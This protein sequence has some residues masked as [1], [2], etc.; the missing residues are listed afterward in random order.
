MKYHLLGVVALFLVLITPALAN[1][2]DYRNSFTRNSYTVPVVVP[3]QQNSSGSTPV[4]QPVTQ[5]GLCINYGHQPRIN[6]HYDQAQIAGDISYLKT[7]GVT[8]IRTADMGTNSTLTENL[9][10][11]F[12]QANF[13]VQIGNDADTLNP[14]SL[15]QYDEG[16]LS[17][18]AWANAHAIDELSLGN[19]QE[20]RLSGMSIA[21]WIAHLKTLAT[22]VRQVY[23][24]KISYAT[25]GDF[26]ADWVK[27]GN[28]GSIDSLGLNLYCSYN[29]NRNY[30]G[31][32]ISAFGLS[33]V[34]VT[35]INCDIANV[36]ACQSDTGLLAETQGDLLKLHS[37]YPTMQM[38]VFAF[39]SGGTAP[40]F[41]DIHLYPLTMKAL[42]L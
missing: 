15:R 42:G 6:G 25:S 11:Q 4:S 34:E 13:Y 32:S 41:W 30:L 14:T 19:E 35:E 12:K 2:Y 5:T 29:C 40:A 22:Q 8:C 26:T 18:A 9:V 10:V 27:A 31:S 37:L 23:T 16:V 36:K 21:F 39:R 7:H 1:R 3:P 24:G 17:E 28:L 38:Y 33:H 20:Y